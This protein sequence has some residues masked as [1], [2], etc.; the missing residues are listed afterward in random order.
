M[1]VFKCDKCKGEFTGHTLARIEL[2]PVCYA[3]F[4]KDYKK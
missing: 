4:L 3:E 2:C 1:T